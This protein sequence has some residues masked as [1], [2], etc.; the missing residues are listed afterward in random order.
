MRIK[1]LYKSDNRLLVGLSK[2]FSELC[3]LDGLVVEVDLEKK[4]IVSGPEGGLNKL[5][6]GSYIP[7][8]QTEKREFIRIL[9]KK[10]KRK[11]LKR[12]EEDLESPS[13]ESIGT[14]VWIPD[15]LGGNGTS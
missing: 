10:L 13:L 9:E 3:V 2:D 14:L 11:A 1:P 7:I 15:R 8:R 6:K 12:I 5:R 4:T